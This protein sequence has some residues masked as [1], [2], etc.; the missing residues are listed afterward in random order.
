MFSTEFQ[1]LD[2]KRV[3]QH[4]N[5]YVLFEDS[6]LADGILINLLFM[7]QSQINNVAT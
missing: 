1:G 3:L 6:V 2:R 4:Q 7:T 5:I